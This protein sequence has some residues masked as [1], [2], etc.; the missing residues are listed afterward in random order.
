MKTEQ[1][2]KQR[3]RQ[4]AAAKVKYR[5]N[6]TSGLCRCGK[7]REVLRWRMCSSCREKAR[8]VYY[9]VRAT[10]RKKREPSKRTP[11]ERVGVKRRDEADGYGH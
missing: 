9:G 10:P 4:T 2:L 6:I 3:K 5:D 7:S 8:G 1:Q 11:S